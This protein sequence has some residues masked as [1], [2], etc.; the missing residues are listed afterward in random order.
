[1]QVFTVLYTREIL[2]P[3]SE[4]TQC[5]SHVR[6]NQQPQCASTVLQ[7]PSLVQAAATG[8]PKPQAKGITKA[9]PSKPASAASL[10]AAAAAAASSA[11][12]V[13]HE[14][15]AGYDLYCPAGQ[16]Q[17]ALQHPAS[18]HM[19]DQL[20]GVRALVLQLQQ[21]AKEL[22]L[23]QQ[24]QMAAAAAAATA[25]EQAAKQEAQQA[26]Q[27]GANQGRRLSAG[28]GSS[29][30]QS[31]RVSRT[32]VPVFADQAGHEGPSNSITAGGLPADCALHVAISLQQSTC[33][34]CGILLVVRTPLHTANSLNPRHPDPHK[35]DSRV[36]A[37]LTHFFYC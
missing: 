1:M 14:T 29:R 18:K 8:P 11:L 10:V 15:A 28:G 17:L 20:M 7:V 9:A 5:T 19:F 3:T 23:L 16:Y 32:N 31:R 27:Q 2:A 21:Q 25:A 36:I 33:S 22:L 26:A 6:L 34:G 12:S 24:Q 13:V 30:P 35:V 4:I 37:V